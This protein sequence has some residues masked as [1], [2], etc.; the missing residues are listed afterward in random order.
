MFIK[1]FIILCLLL[2]TF[3]CST[4]KTAQLNKISTNLFSDKDFLKPISVDQVPDVYYLSQEQKEWLDTLVKPSL[5]STFTRQLINKLF[6]KNYLG[7]SYDNSFT[8]TA[9]ETLETKTGNCL[10]MVILSVAIAKHFD[11]DYKVFDIKTVPIWNKS[12]GLF[13]L[14]GHVNIQ[15]KN[16][17]NSDNEYEF[18]RERYLTLDF[19]PEES[20]R[21]LSKEQ[22]NERQLSGIYY[23]NLAADA[24]VKKEWNKA[25]W[26]LKKSIS[27]APNYNVAW[28]SLGVV[29]RNNGHDK[30]AENVYEHALINDPND[31]NIL[32]NYAILLSSQGRIEEL[33]QYKEKIRQA[34]LKNPYRYFDK[35]QEAYAQL[36][37]E[38]AIKLYKK[39]IKISPYVDE[40]YFGLFQS[41]LAIN[42]MEL[43]VKYLK[44][45]HNS[46]TTILDRN[47]YNNKLAILTSRY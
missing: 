4:T 27:H 36:D 25:Y 2:L 24:M 18:F 47:R 39:A 14:N 28:N 37:F 16:T 45:A 9:T 32:A 1:Y 44:V 33:A 17:Y 13:V 38:S 10:S 5:S 43:A 34:R 6:Q 30:L 31:T 23:T 41:Y 7:F 29:Y 12:G 11:I 8:R 46:S 15:L 21:T 19:L 26:L 35:A 3:G 42:E 22:I 40:F 20:R